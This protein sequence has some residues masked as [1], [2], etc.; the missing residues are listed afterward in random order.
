[1]A[2]LQLRPSEGHSEDIIEYYCLEGSEGKPSPSREKTCPG[3]GILEDHRDH[4]GFVQMLVTENAVT[5]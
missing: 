5:S 4:L 2:G 3:D 1:M